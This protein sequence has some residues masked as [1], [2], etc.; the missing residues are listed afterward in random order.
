MNPEGF[1]YAGEEAYSSGMLQDSEY[2]TF[3]TNY[4]A[5]EYGMVGPR[6][7]RAQIFVYA[8]MEGQEERFASEAMQAKLERI[9]YLLRKAYWMDKGEMAVWE[10][11]LLPNE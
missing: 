8:V 9:C 3:G 5:D 2:L 1:V 6:E 11:Y 4:F 7:D 10:Q